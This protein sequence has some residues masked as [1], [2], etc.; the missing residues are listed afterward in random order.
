MNDIAKFDTAIN[1]GTFIRFAQCGSCANIKQVNRVV[2]LY[3]VIA[4]FKSCVFQKFLIFQSNCIIFIYNYLYC[5][6]HLYLYNYIIYVY[7][8]LHN[9]VTR[10]YF[11]YSEFLFINV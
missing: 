2:Y 1:R 8:Y 11:C 10:I 5:V 7:I 3:S 6:L 9:M 4:S